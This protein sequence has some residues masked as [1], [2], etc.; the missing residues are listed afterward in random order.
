MRIRTVLLTATILSTACSAA[1]APA[2]S[3]SPSAATS[4]PVARSATSTPVPLTFRTSAQQARTVATLVA[5]LDAYDAGDVSRAVALLSDDVSISDCDN[6]GPKV[7]A[8]NGRDAAR[9]WLSERAA[10][11][12]QLVL[13]SIR[14][15]NPDPTTGSH[16][17]AVSYTRRTSDTLRALGFP[18]GIEPQTATKAVFTA[19]DDRLRAFANG[20]FGGPIDLCRPRP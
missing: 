11:H 7:L 10:D 13:E 1:V 9:Q 3:P 2:S 16:V 6:R 19:T 15:E 4:T 12:D 5:F 8:P 18:N 17:V 14:N 20:P